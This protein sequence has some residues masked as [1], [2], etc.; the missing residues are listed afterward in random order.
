MLFRGAE[1]SCPNIFSI[2]WPKIK[3]FCP[4]ITQFVLPE[5][6]YLDK[7]R[8]RVGVGSAGPPPPYAYAYEY[9]FLSEMYPFWSYIMINVRNI[10]KIAWFLCSRRPFC[11]WRPFW[12]SGQNCN[13][14]LIKLSLVYKNLP[15]YQFLQLFLKMNNRRILLHLCICTT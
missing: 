12:I 13:G 2:A 6:G 10:F 15:L 11:F 14:L 7:Y 8:V 4:N 9:L 5:N 1:I 3:R